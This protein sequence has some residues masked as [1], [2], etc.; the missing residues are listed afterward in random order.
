MADKFLSFDAQGLV[1]DP[2]NVGLFLI[3]LNILSILF[4]TIES[5]QTVGNL[6]RNFGGRFRKYPLGISINCGGLDLVLLI[7]A[8][9]GSSLHR[10]CIESE[11]HLPSD[12]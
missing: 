8:R 3:S 1:R 4:G 11:K 6:R 12:L 2:R 7:T 9:F 5:R 10:V